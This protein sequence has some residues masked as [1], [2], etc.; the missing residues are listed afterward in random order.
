MALITVQLLRDAHSVDKVF[1]KMTRTRQR[2]LVY[3]R[4]HFHP[5]IAVVDDYHDV[6]IAACSRW[7][8]QP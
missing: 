1:D 7:I 4:H 5:F 2:R 8:K 6:A 3:H